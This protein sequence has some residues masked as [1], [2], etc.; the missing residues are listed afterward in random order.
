MQYVPQ[1]TII[2]TT[3]GGGSGMPFSSELPNGWGVR[4]SACS[5]LDPKGNVTEFGI[6][7]TE[8]CR[9]ALDPEAAIKGHDTIIDFA[10]KLLTGN[11]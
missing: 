2:G 4:F 5:V 8:G 7:P 3:T 9:V 6:E 11:N 10:V 1:T